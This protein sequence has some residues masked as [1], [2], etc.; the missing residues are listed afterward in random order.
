MFF[1]LSKIL[2]FALTPVVWIATLLLL[3]FFWKRPRWKRRFA[4]A[5]L[6]VFFFFSNGFIFDEYNRLW[7]VPTVNAEE[8]TPCDIG[9]VLGGFSAYDPLMDRVEF[10]H[11]SDRLLIAMELYHRGIIKKIMISGG[12]GSLV[13]QDMKE[14]DHT[15]HYLL[16][17][18]IP[19]EDILVE[20]Q[21]VNTHENAVNSKAFLDEN[22]PE[23]SILLITSANHMRR[24]RAC[25]AKVGMEFQYLSVDRQSG[26][27]KFY[28]DHMFIPDSNVLSLWTSALKELVGYT[29]Y[30]TIG[31]V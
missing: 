30:W 12:S 17:V 2:Y 1:Y 31:Y 4:I 27:R 22:Y 15:R 19:D 16:R 9:I 3:A 25:F 11:S 26:D 13:D 29:V 6:V 14:A 5:S 21:S 7:E 8:L 23:A 18:G 28:F 10:S 20:N 24:A